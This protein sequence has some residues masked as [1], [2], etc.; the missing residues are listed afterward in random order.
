MDKARKANYEL[1][2][3][4]ATVVP[5]LKDRTA[6]MDAAEGSWYNVFSN[7]D[8]NIEDIAFVAAWNDTDVFRKLDLNGNQTDSGNNILIPIEFRFTTFGVSGVK[9]GDMFR[10]IDLPK[11][12][13]STIFQVVEV[14]HEL[15]NGLWQTSVTGKMRN[16]GG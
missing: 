5:K 9:T 1:F 13:T 15:S 4:K 7:S 14:S 3:S 8:A 16:I 2:M 12:Y 10:I 11:Q 6:D